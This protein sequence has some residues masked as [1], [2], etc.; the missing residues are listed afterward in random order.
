VI[1][2]SI[3]L[4][5]V[6]V[7]RGRHTVHLAPGAAGD[8][9]I[10]LIGGQNGRG[11]TTLMD[12]IHFALYGRSARLAKRG[13]LSWEDFLRG[14]INRH[15]PITEG[16]TIELNLRFHSEGNEHHVRV[17]RGWAVREAKLRENLSVWMDGEYSIELGD[18]WPDFV[19]NLIPSRIAHLFLFDGE[20]IS[21][22]ADPERS[23]E[24]LKTGIYALLGADLVG[25]LEMDLLALGRRFRLE[26]ASASD[27]K[28]VKLLEKSCIEARQQLEDVIASIEQKQG[29]LQT[30]KLKRESVQHDVH[31]Q[32]GHLLG[33][34]EALEQEERIVQGEIN[35]LEDENRR[36]LAANLPL[37]W[38]KDLLH[39]IGEQAGKEQALNGTKELLA[40]IEDRDS[41]LLEFLQGEKPPPKVLQQVKSWLSSD[42]Q[43]ISTQTNGTKEIYGFSADGYAR[44]HALLWGGLD[45]DST[46]HEYTASSLK[47]AKKAL[48]GVQRKLARIPDPD[49]VHLL[50]DQRTQLDKLISHLEVEIQ[51]K[52]D[53]SVE[54]KTKCGQVDRVLE[55]RTIELN[56]ARLEQSRISRNLE[57]LERA[58]VTVEKFKIALIARDITRIENSILESAKLL[59]SKQKLVNRVKID[60]VSFHLSIFDSTGEEFSP[61]QLS[62]GERQILAISILWGLSKASGKSLPVFIDTP[63]GRLDHDH[64]D[65]LVATYFHK[66]S[67]QMVLLSTEE[68]ITPTQ[69]RTMSSWVGNIYSLIY[70]ESTQCS[71]FE[72]GKFFDEVQPLPTKSQ[73]AESVR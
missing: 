17:L 63:L 18:D 14:L 23:K 52:I 15:A 61:H 60:P 48:E 50:L 29:E 47:S 66:A 36:Q 32:G 33:H 22:L 39:E 5:N 1:I 3:T 54:L 68:E 64:R 27:L 67:H 21:A 30:M 9:P 72:T 71:H 44:L 45:E 26:S 8:R 69:F 46:K 62:A 2:E 59:F 70:E 11:K 49:A 43:A 73:F 34:R 42:R 57:H 31:S 4:F 41:L 53:V 56:S 35:R 10:V 51:G 55:K 58:K 16:A 25:R 40:K 24:I 12:S 20:Q 38:V 7:F 65:R 19:E 6:G 28:E 13:D 37:V